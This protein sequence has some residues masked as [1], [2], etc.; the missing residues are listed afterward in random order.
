MNDLNLTL[1]QSDLFWEDAEKNV[2]HF[3][4]LIH[5]INETTHLI[6][7][8]EMFST[9]FSMQ[10]KKLAETMDGPT[11]RW[12]KEKA[13]EKNCAVTGSIIICEN[14]FFYNRLIWVMPDA[15]LFFYNKRHLFSLANEQQHYTQGKEKLIVSYKGW[16]IFPLIC[17]DLRFPVWCRNKMTS[18][19]QNCDYDLMLFVANWPHRRID[20][21]N[22]L[23]IA[24]AI[25]NQ[26]YV[27]GVNRIGMDGNEIYHSGSTA[28]IDPE[29]KIIFR[30]SEKP[31][32][33]TITLSLT[34]LQNSRNKF[35]FLKDS[36][37]FHIEI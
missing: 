8:P 26:S 9:G 29:G 37:S 35:R 33:T 25:E 30:A 7:L 17:Y 32:I 4:R 36:D 6:V 3:D 22:Q 1:I 34:E 2:A 16:H 14:N 23:L 27:A 21:W 20:A 18:E 31:L 11:I 12:M 10:C 28:L 19:A 15:S 24:R 5:N 13:K